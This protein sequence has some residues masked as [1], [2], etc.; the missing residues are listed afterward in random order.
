MISALVASS[1]SI[2]A[3]LPFADL[4]LDESSLPM[5]CMTL[6]KT[7]AISSALAYFRYTTFTF[8]ARCNGVS[9]CSTKVRIRARWSSSPVTNTLLVLGSDTRST[10]S[11]PPACA[12]SDLFSN[13][14]IFTTS[15]AT[16]YSRGR[17]SV[18]C[19][20]DRS[21]CEIRALIRS[22]LEA[23]SEITMALLGV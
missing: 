5:F 14:N 7:C 6:V 18:S 1:A 9:K 2:V 10:V 17:M 4:L 23:I 19:I 3:S 15:S 13:C 16:A 11:S 21:I 12:A 22:I 8:P 20:A